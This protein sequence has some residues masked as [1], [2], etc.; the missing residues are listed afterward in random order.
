M[1]TNKRPRFQIRLSDAQMEATTRSLADTERVT[2]QLE[3]EMYGI[4]SNEQKR[5]KKEFSVRLIQ[6]E[7]WR[8]TIGIQALQIIIEQCIIHFGYP[9]IHLFI[10]ISE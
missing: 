8:E 7:S 3:S 5:F 10:N 2:H 6:F 9:E 1:T 4:T